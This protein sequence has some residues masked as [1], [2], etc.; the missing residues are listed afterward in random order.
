MFT[1]TSDNSAFR[2][3]AQGRATGT[4]LTYRLFTASECAL[5]LTRLDQEKL[6][7][8]WILYEGV[9]GGVTT[10]LGRSATYTSDPKGRLGITLR[11][12]VKDYAARTDDGKVRLTVYL[13]ET[14]GTAVDSS[15]FIAAPVPGIDNYELP[16][17]YGKDAKDLGVSS[18][19]FILPPNVI[20]APP[21]GVKVIV[22]SDA[23]DYANCSW[24]DVN[25][26][27]TITPTGPRGN[28][29]E[30]TGTNQAMGIRLEQLTR[31]M[32]Y[33]FTPI[34]CDNAI[35]VRWT[36][37]T[38]ATR[39]HLFPVLS[40][41]RSSEDLGLVVLGDGI[42][43]ERNAVVGVRCRLSGLTSYGY[44]YY[45]D[46]LTASDVHALPLNIEYNASDVNALIASE[47][48]AATVEGGSAEVPVGGSFHNFDFTI[49]L[50]H[51]DT[52]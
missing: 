32:T 13:N 26:N 12:P 7:L 16:M 42:R 47:L 24:K 4:P 2:L 6:S 10:T 1:I 36:S 20:I 11:R 44:W 43:T 41:V 5:D 21:V 3:E 19:N 8:Y 22:E 15:A 37:L 51:Y 49:K 30:Y 34:G 40:Q 48:S 52:H 50:R 9:V 18:R 39:Q 31:S 38:G 14:S 33:G 27:T 17:P 25:G 29:I 23:A 45:M 46:L 35:L 28:M